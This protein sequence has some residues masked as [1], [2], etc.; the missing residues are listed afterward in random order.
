[1]SITTLITGTS[2]GI[3]HNLC[4]HFITKNHNVIS[5]ARTDNVLKHKNLFHY[6]I[7][8]TDKSPSVT[9][10][11]IIKS[12]NINN[13]ILNAGI[14]K[15][16]MFHKMSFDDWFDTINTNLI[17]IHNVL[18]PILNNMRENNSGNIILTA[19]VLGKLGSMGTSNYSA[20]K[21]ALYGLTRSLALENAHKN[22]LIN[23]I[24]P[25]YINEG[26]GATIIPKYKLKLNE[27]IPLKRF[28]EID[29]VINIID[30][31][32]EKN[33]YMTGSNID[34]NGGMI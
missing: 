3:G 34:I 21:S 20:S 19:S 4:K 25:G 1:M 31:L 32:T 5:I 24:S 33:K 28:G 8:I 10:K 18:F 30:Y 9:I 2:R 27:Q 6:N 29:D 11:N 22:I 16:S 26:M 13:C 7:D 15:D 12:T 23:S 14:N 17:S